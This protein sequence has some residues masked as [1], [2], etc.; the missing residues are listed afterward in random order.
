[1]D[2][3]IPKY[4]KMYGT[5]V[6]SSRSFPLDI[7]GLKPVERRIL[8]SAFQI[9]KDKNVKCAKISG[10]VMG[11][12][13][14]HGDCYGT[15]VQL[16]H[17]GFLEGQGNFGTNIGVEPVPAAASR[18]TECRLSKTI[19]E[20]AFK[21]INYVPWVVNDL[22]EKEPV[23]LPTMFP[24]C[25]MGKEYTQ[26]IGFGYRTYIPTF[27]IKDLY[28]RLLWL[29]KKSKNK[30]V[31]KPISTCN[32]TSTPKEIEQLF[33][34]GKGKMIVNGVMVEQPHVSK[35][36]LKSWPPGRKFESFL[37]RF[38]KELDNQDIGFTDLSVTETKI[39]F[40]VLKR[41]NR[42]LIYTN[43]VEKLKAALTGSIPFEI[44]V[45][46]KDSNI[47]QASIDSMLLN[48]YKVYSKIN[49]AMLHSEIIRINNIISEYKILEKIRPALSTALRGKNIIIDSAIDQISTK[50]GLE[51]G[52]LKK[53]FS[54]YSIHK[55][56]SLNT[57][58]KGHQDQINILNNNLT[59]LQDFVL[60]QY[61]ELING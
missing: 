51:K 52:Q 53:L 1:M 35:V 25:L 37:N 27:N 55:L 38:S 43:F 46:D 21:L 49:K 3:L 8:L 58:I 31:I 54:K 14:P 45:V 34:Q 36:V 13:H 41:R 28:K 23:F 17:Q 2:Q 18:Y 20:L 5:Y 10:H 11:N 9:A 44:I 57:D 32:I 39:V 60:N 47:K 61:E 48:T 50:T 15:I 59:N 16:V 6:N 26:G 30:Q 12:Y 22:G 40:E 24:L 19:Q 56:L 29:L 33:T 42:D 7:D 4:Y